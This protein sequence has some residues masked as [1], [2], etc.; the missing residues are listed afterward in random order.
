MILVDMGDGHY[1][2]VVQPP[3]GQVLRQGNPAGGTVPV[4][5]RLPAAAV[6]DHDEDAAGAG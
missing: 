2:N 1:V 3:E 5:L 6:D 4:L